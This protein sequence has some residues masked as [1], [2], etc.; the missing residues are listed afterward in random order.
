MNE[1]GFMCLGANAVF[2]P[3]GLL[4]TAGTHSV[5]GAYCVSVNVVA[6]G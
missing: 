1:L 3:S 4:R 2:K 5:L 6:S